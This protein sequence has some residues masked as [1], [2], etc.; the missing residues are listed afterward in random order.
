MLNFITTGCSFTAGTIPL[1]HD[2]LEHWTTHSSVWPHFC[3]ADM[4]PEQD[5]FVNLAMPGAGNVAALLTLIYFLETNK[6]TVTPDNAIVAFNITGLNRLDTICNINDPDINNNLCCIDP[7]GIEHPS[8]AMNFGW[9]TQG[10]KHKIDHI[11]IQAQLTILQAMCYLDL[12]KFKYCFMLMTNS[13]YNDS[14]PWFQQLLDQHSKHW[15]K[16]DDIM[17]MKEF[18]QQH[19]LTVSKFDLHPNTAGHKLIAKY[20][21]KFIKQND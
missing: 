9:K 14:Q 5:R 7:R 12:H 13:I 2:K 21:T 8:V 3:F 20:V 10:F 16:F 17:G 11:D 18:V 19:N 6:S 1:P 4:N 15:I